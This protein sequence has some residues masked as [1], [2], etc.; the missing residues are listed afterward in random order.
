MEEWNQKSQSDRQFPLV[1]SEHRSNFPTR[2]FLIE[3]FEDC[4]RCRM[5]D[6]FRCRMVDCFLHW[7]VDCF[8]YWMID[9]AIG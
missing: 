3:G 4:F 6:C 8:R 5:V 7:M 2:D 9:W 1:M